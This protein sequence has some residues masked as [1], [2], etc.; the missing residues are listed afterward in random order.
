MPT[1]TVGSTAP[2]RGWVLVLALAVGQ[3]ISWGTTFYSFPLVIDPM[4]AELGWQRTTAYMAP[5]FGLVMQAFCAPLAGFWMQRHGGRVSMTIGSFA[6]AASILA[7]SAVSEPWQLLAA[8]GVMGMA[9]AFVLYESAF[10]VV[11]QRKALDFGRSVGAITLLGGLAGT[12]FVPG[13]QLLVELFGWRQAVLCL[14]AINL[15]VP[16]ILHALLVP[17]GN[18]DADVPPQPE[19]ASAAAPPPTGLSPRVW[20][21][22]ALWLTAGSAYLSGVTFHFVPLLSAEGLHPTT[23]ASIFAVVGPSQLLGRACLMTM[24]SRV[25]AAGAGLIAVV[26]VLMSAVMLWLLP[27][28]PPWLIAFAVIY[29][30]GNGIL[31]ITRGIAIAE[32]AGRARYATVSGI[33]QMPAGLA[34]AFAPV[35]VSVVRDAGGADAVY[36]TFLTITL[37]AAAGFAIALLLPTRKAPV[38]LPS[39]R[40][41]G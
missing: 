35:I 12:V 27:H 32:V 22:L 34:L 25:T 1:T 29:G 30:G 24:G 23:L 17:S 20:L 33:L 11:A 14:A 40:P 21:G 7:W 5:A 39:T 15:A 3:L 8:W 9:Q 13:T 41:S 2:S 19:E 28:S 31:T 37:I 10:T 26:M 6:V 36:A 16:M 18:G 38:D 4:T